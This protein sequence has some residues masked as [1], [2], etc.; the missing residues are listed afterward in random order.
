MR[1]PAASPVRLGR[2]QVTEP[3]WAEG[4]KKL[5]VVSVISQ[6]ES[7]HQ[8]AVRPPFPAHALVLLIEEVQPHAGRQ[9]AQ[10]EDCQDAE[11][12]EKAQPAALNNWP[13]QLKARIEAPEPAVRRFVS[14]DGC[15]E[16]LAACSSG[17][18][19]Q[20]RLG[21]QCLTH[22]SNPHSNAT[23]GQTPG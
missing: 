10:D 16:A 1:W 21:K 18:A 14:R 19:V 20:C 3:G 23:G 7:R 15:D 9:Q 8:P 4:K 22:C 5:S 2:A 13:V 6:A 17:S 11:Q 12:D